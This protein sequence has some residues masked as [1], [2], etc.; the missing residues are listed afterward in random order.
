[1][2][3]CFKKILLLVSLL[4]GCQTSV[5]P[6]P[7]GYPA[8]Q[9]SS[10]VTDPAEN[11]DQSTSPIAQSPAQ[12]A[13]QPAAQATPYPRRLYRLRDQV[14]ANSPFHQFRERLKQAI[15]DRDAEFIAAIADP[16]IKT[17]FGLPVPFS[18]LD[19]DNPNSLSWKRLERI[20]DIGCTP[21]EAPAGVEIDAYQCPH[22]SQASLG[23]PFSD[24]YIVGENVQVRAQPRA[25]S[26][27]I[28][29][30]S[31]EVVNADPAE[32]AR[33][34]QQQQQEQQTVEG[35][36]PIVTSTGQ[37]GYVSSRYAYYPAGYRARFEQQQG[38]WKMTVFIAG[39]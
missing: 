33:L 21:Y 25:D 13:S 39:D 34:T 29:A 20:I 14:P 24:V 32:L 17:T 36:Q 38:D 19:F 5:N 4:A 37:R 22:V 6:P 26:P 2:K 31:D 1:M 28:D 7:L 16:E 35:W 23:D 10:P 18:S 8:A 3:F 12:S 27:V 15:R 11:A 30:V 9:Q